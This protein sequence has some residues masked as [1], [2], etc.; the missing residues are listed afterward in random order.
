M[1][2]KGAHCVGLKV[3]N[4]LPSY[5]MNTQQDDN[6]FKW[7]LRNC[8]YCNALYTLAETLNNTESK[9]HKE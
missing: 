4:R 6:E 5:V 1:V 7:L 3:F 9:V 8:L 2:D